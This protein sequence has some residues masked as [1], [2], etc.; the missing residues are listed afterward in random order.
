ML[1]HFGQVVLQLLLQFF[2]HSGHHLLL[3]QLVVRGRGLGRLASRLEVGGEVGGRMF[4]LVVL[5]DVRHRD[6]CLLALVALKQVLLC[7]LFE[8]VLVST[9]CF[10]FDF[11]LSPETLVLFSQRSEA[12]LHTF[13][14]L[15]RLLV[16]VVQT[17]GK[18]LK[19]VLSEY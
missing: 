2:P 10:V 5:L 7:R 11:E 6:K 16:M 3:N 12:G 9:Q 18:R 19:I 8:Q 15:E 1:L 4:A 14:F 13:G 17:F